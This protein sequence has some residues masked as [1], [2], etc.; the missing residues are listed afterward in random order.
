MCVCVLL[1]LTLTLTLCILRAI[2]R[3]NL[4]SLFA[5]AN[6]QTNVSKFVRKERMRCA[7][8]FENK[9]FVSFSSSL[10]LLFCQLSRLSPKFA[11]VE[12]V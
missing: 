8:N 6:E 3:G 10:F 12:K 5:L 9:L 1:T 2:D 11:A 4:S 7:A